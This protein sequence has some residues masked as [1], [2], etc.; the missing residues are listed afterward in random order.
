MTR[1]DFRAVRRRANNFASMSSVR[2][3]RLAY[4][5]LALGI[6]A[7]ACSSGSPEG[8]DP[9]DPGA[10]TGGLAA[11]DSAA[12]T[13]GLDGAGSGGG[14]VVV[15]T[16]ICATAVEAAS[17]TLTCPE[18]STI[19]SIDFASFGTSTGECGAFAQNA[20]HAADSQA[21]LEA[22]CLGQGTCSV[23]A[24]NEAFGGDPCPFVEK[25][26]NV[27]ATC[28]GTTDAGG[29]G[30]AGS[31]G[32]GTATGGTGG[33][34]I[35]FPDGVTSLFP[36]PGATN[37]CPDPS[38][39]LSF[40][41]VPSLGSAGSVKVFDAS[42]PGSPVATVDFGVTTITDQIGGTT[43]NLPRQVYVD[44]NDV[45]IN[46]KSHALGYDKTYFVTVDQGAIKGPGNSAF[47]I[48]DNEDWTFS[49]FASAPSNTTALS[50]AL[51]G[52][53]DFCSPQGALDAV[54]SNN[55]APTKI[56]I[57]T[58][59]Y[60]GV[61]Y[62]S[63]KQNITLKG[64]DRKKTILSG[65]NNN[66]LNPGAK[67]RALVG[68]DSTHGLV[69]ENLTIHNL[70][71]QNGS[72]AE[73]LRLQKCDKC[74]VRD[75]DILSLQDTLLWTGRIYAENCFIAGNVDFVWGDGAVYFDHCEIKTVGR[76]GPIV[77]SRN[78][79]S[80]YGYVFVDSRITSDPGRSGSVLARIDV[81][82]YP[83]SHVAYINCELGSHIASVGWT[84]TG[85][86]APSSLRFWE[87]Q[88]KNSSGNLINTSGRAAGSKQ[89]NAQQ[90]AS[91]RDKATVFGGWNPN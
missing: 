1:V 61:V 10:S 66:N 4:L 7:V 79:A 88:S 56:D 5:S 89:I 17:A 52:T 40:S 49:T 38:L 45:V 72:Q 39:R 47:S 27:Q 15:M 48:N 55:T 85:G 87:Y 33:E 3:R 73:A 46:L 62:F 13:G 25:N 77:Q 78:P 91:M 43:F 53:G 76:D 20:C 37:T 6:G 30:S 22:A 18:G 71:P 32:T 70:T 74:I 9:L 75:A 84:I 41:G 60:H 35:E 69:V 21:V 81:S 14:S 57:G 29:S 51:D 54:P 44:G 19:T 28:T 86:S 64:A 67:G 2:L 11:P 36:L 63:G 68:A 34:P 82:E 83:D 59:T 16:T 26:L 12:G 90:A 8:T 42:A 80:G 58:G 24:L 50:V 23:E 31:G 65:V